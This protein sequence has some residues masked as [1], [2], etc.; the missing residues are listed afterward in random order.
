MANE[1]SKYANALAMREQ[2]FRGESA[3]IANMAGPLQS[4]AAQTGAP[5]NIDP[6]EIASVSGLANIQAV[7]SGQSQEREKVGKRSVKRMPSYV[8][9][10]KNYLQWRYPTR[11]GG[12]SGYYGGGNDFDLA[13]LP[14][15]MPPTGYQK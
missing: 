15:L 9:A 10:Y 12:S 14:D 5:S 2:G 3:N 7:A 13:P 1:F 6:S 8:K 11:Y 4:I